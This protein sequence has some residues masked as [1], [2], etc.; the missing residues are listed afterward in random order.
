MA[1]EFLAVL[2]L[3]PNDERVPLR[4]RAYLAAQ[5]L[6]CT[7]KA[8]ITC[9]D[10]AR[11]DALEPRQKHDLSLLAQIAEQLSKTGAK[12]PTRARR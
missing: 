4:P 2:D 12:K 11:R 9:V 10:T 6:E 1:D 3:L 8:F 5:A 7:L